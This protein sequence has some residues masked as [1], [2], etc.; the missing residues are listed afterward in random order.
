MKFFSLY[1]LA[2][3]SIFL[4]CGSCVIALGAKRSTPEWRAAQLEKRKKKKQVSRTA[5]DAGELR[6]TF[7]DVAGQIAAKEALEDIIDYL[8]DPRVYE[9]MGARMPRGVLLVGPPGNGKT[10][11]ARAVA[12]ETNCKFIAVV[13]SQFEEV[14]VGLGASRIR[15]LFKEAREAPNGCIIF[16]DEIDS[17][18]SRRDLFGHS[19]Q[20]QTLNQILTEMDGFIAGSKIMVIGATNRVEVLDSALLR[21][22]RFDRQV[23]VGNPGFADRME[24][25]RIHARNKPLNADIDF[26]KLAQLTDGCS[27]ATLENIMNEAALLAIKRRK[28]SISMDILLDT[29]RKCV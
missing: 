19:A 29:I 15:D 17:L 12:G 4:L 7:D 1:T 11:I 27:Y 2:V 28:N 9:R 20:A 21:P 6:V 13:A 16:I 25:L 24:G 3:S 8:R 26:E 14:W 18:G 23:Y 10:L 22:G 5:T